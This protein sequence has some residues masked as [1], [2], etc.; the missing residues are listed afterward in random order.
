[1]LCHR[2][3]LG[4]GGKGASMGIISD[5]AAAA[6]ACFANV[7][8]FFFSSR[9]GV[10]RGDPGICDF[11]FGNPQE[12]PLPGLVDTIQRHAVPLN[13]N[14]YAYKTSEDEPRAFIAERLGAE[15]GIA[16][17]PEDIALTAG[18]FG[19]ISLA[20]GLLL[21]PGDEEVIPRYPAGSATSP[22]CAR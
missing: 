7:R 9:Y 18:A 17:A 8:E 5:R 2:A 22:C 3:T 21:A 1:M 13:K 6:G 11:T 19:A 15:L 12:L 20:F 16:F 10:R 14:W 4:S